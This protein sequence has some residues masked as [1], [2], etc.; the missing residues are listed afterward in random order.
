MDAAASIEH[1]KIA[2]WNILITAGPVL[3]VALLVGIVVGVLQA[4][5]SI[6][7]A[8]IGFVPK[9]GIVLLTMA[10]MASFMLG[11]MTD[12]FTFV[13]QTIATLH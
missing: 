9:L 5:T 3:G 12:Y 8:T 7:D 11:R 1:L 13:F 6:N 2:Y 10:L 4:A